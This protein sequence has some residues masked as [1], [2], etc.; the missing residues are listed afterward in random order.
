MSK[1]LMLGVIAALVLATGCSKDDLTG[2]ADKARN[3]A[4]QAIVKARD[5]GKLAVDR[6][7]AA[8]QAAAQQASA[9]AKRSREMAAKA[10]QAAEDAKKA[11]MAFG[12]SGPQT[13]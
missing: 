13:N 8:A 7:D 2:Q 5:A 9:A 3:A 1:P 6:A 12:Q 4:S 11:A 10:A